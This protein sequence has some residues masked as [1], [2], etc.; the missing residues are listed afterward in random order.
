MFPYLPVY[1]AHFFPLKKAP[2]IEMRIIHGMLS[3]LDLHPSL[4]YTQI[5]QICPYT[6]I[7]FY[8]KSE[9]ETITK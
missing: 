2:K 9:T 4:V 6:F 8:L 5:R 1:N 7:G 3:F